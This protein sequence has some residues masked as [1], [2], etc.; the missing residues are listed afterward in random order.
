[1]QVRRFWEKLS[2]FAA[3]CATTQPIYAPSAQ[4]QPP[5]PAPAPVPRLGILV[6]IIAAVI[7]WG[8]FIAA[9]KEAKPKRKK[10]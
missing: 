8:L 6:V 3:G 2:L 1:M 4:P 7:I 9:F 10:K 5:A